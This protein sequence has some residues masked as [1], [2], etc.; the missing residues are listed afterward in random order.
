LTLIQSALCR[1][2]HSADYAA[3]RTM[4]SRFTRR[5]VTAGFAGHCSA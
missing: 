4:P 2:R 5:L 1:M 3:H